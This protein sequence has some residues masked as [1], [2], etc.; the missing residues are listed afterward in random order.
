MKQISVELIKQLRE[1][2]GAGIM[3]CKKVL[4]DTDGNMERALHLLRLRGFE[5]AEKKAEKEVKEG[6]VGAYIHHNGKIGVLVELACQ[7]DFVA[8]NEEFKELL[9]DLCLHIAAMRPLSISKDDLPE[10]VVQEYKKN[11]LE[12]IKDKP[13]KLIDRILEG[14]MQKYLYAEKCLLHQQF[15][16]QEKFSGTVDELIKSKIAKFG[17][18]IKVVR[19]SRFELGK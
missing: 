4:E 3:D 2:T 11:F 5:K 10:E 13:P 15:A 9:R 14:K 17:E 7:T 12:E 1:K 8:N 19:F 6:R 18:N 16:N